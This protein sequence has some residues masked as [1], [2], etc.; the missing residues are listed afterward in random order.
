MKFRF[1]VVIFA[2]PD[3]YNIF[4]EVKLVGPGYEEHA[5][6]KVVE[7]GEFHPG[8]TRNVSC[9]LFNSEIET[10]YPGE[11]TYKT[12]LKWLKWSKSKHKEQHAIMLEDGW[13]Y[14]G[15]NPREFEL[16]KYVDSY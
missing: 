2:A 4:E 16:W 14:L 5:Y 8:L 3:S 11:D 13:V 15:D 10:Y 12:K 7:A 1:T 6:T 9:E